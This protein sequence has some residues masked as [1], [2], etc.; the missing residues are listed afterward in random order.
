MQIKVEKM[1]R[2]T[3]K[4]DS[5]RDNWRRV[6]KQKTMKRKLARKTKQFAQAS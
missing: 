6:N 4:N 5:Q 3:P 2:L 1:K